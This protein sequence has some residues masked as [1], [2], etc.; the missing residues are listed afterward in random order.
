MFPPAANAKA[1]ID[2]DGKGFI[3]D[4]ER[5]HLNSGSIHYPRAQ[6]SARTA[7]C[8][9]GARGGFNTVQTYV[10]WN[11][12][13]PQE[14]HFD[15][16]GEKDFEAYL[17]VAQDLG[18]YVTVCVGPYVC[19]EWDSG[20]Y[21]V[22]AKFKPDVVVRSNNPGF[23]ALQDHWL[24]EI[25]PRVA[26]HQI[27]RGGNVILLQLEN[28]ARGR[29]LGGEGHGS[30]LPGPL[31]QRQETRYRGPLLHREWLQPRHFARAG[32]P[33]QLRSYLSAISTETY[34]CWYSNYGASDYQYM[35]ILRSN[36]KL[37]WGQR[38]ELLHARWRHQ[39]RFVER[40][41]NGRH[42]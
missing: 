3:I 15:F 11:Y 33:R 40:Q 1:V 26:A 23:I 28:E 24:A 20:G 41:R 30:V 4:G 31:R 36:S 37:L 14:N 35:R 5:T 21:P 32:E 34:P 13:E 18:L 22:W 29:S 27:H 10:F 42:L 25:L 12:H 9:Y 16:H 19:A 8:A 2:Y 39:L 38:P 6:G 7:C 17:K